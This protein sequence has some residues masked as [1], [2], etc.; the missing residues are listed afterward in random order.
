MMSKDKSKTVQGYREC[1]GSLKGLGL[2][3]PPCRDCGQRR[4]TPVWVSWRAA[5]V[6]LGK[7]GFSSPFGVSWGPLGGLFWVLLVSSWAPGVTC[8]GDLGSIS[9]P[10]GLLRSPRSLLGPSRARAGHLALSWGPLGPSWAPPQ[11]LGGPR[12]GSWRPGF[13][14]QGTF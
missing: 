2:V 5:G 14:V 8:W 13:L 12:S 3:L 6:L 9:G 4:V 7:A 1:P 10:L 11:A